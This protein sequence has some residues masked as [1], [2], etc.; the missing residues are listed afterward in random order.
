[1]NFKERISCW[2]WALK[3]FNKIL[4]TSTFLNQVEVFE[5]VR[6]L[7]FYAGIRSFFRSEGIIL[8]PI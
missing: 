7:I 8:N 5:P 4:A 2:E 1:M 6:I 3:I